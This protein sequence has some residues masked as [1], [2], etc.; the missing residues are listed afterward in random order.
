MVA[1]TSSQLGSLFVAQPYRHHEMLKQHTYSTPKWQRS[2]V[3]AVRCHL[4]SH[5]LTV[6]ML[7]ATLGTYSTLFQSS[8]KSCRCCFSPFL[9]TFWVEINLSFQVCKSHL[10]EVPKDL[11]Q[12]AWFPCAPRQGNAQDPNEKMP[13]GDEGV[14]LKVSEGVWSGTKDLFVFTQLC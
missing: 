1:P 11:L 12:A 8:L 6:F 7:R 3:W 9:A 4:G 13:L 2:S 5:I 10:H 14:W